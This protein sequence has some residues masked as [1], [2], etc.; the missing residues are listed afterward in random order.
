ME[1]LQFERNKIYEK[2]AYQPEPVDYTG[3]LPW[4]VQQQIA[5]TNGIHYVDR[6]GKLNWYPAYELPVKQSSGGLMLDIGTGWGR[7]LV[8]GARKGFLPIGVDLRLEFCQAS[9]QTLAN[10]KINGYAVVADLKELPFED[11]IFSLIWSFSVIQH[12]H[13]VR[14]ES[15]LDNIARMLKKNGI[16]KIQVPNSKGLRNRLGPAKT[17]QRTADQ[18]NSWVVR[19]YSLNEYKRI[20]QKYFQNLSFRNHSF[21]GIGVLKEDMKYVSY[22]NKLLCSAS[23]LLSGLTKFVKPLI[24][25]SDSIYVEALKNNGGENREKINCFL[26]AHRKDP[27]NNLNVV[28]ILQCPISKQNL[29]LTGDKQAIV[30]MDG[31]ISYPVKDSIPV[32]IRSEATVCEA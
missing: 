22:K 24:H 15:C 31:K 32:M 10:H 1:N 16:T 4:L 19:Y 20:F 25:F 27:S 14:M 3:K 13:R 7:W 6:I 12:T 17:S 30:T 5:A 26:E 18:Y 21:L 8:A 23:L 28:H 29:R 2:L 11:D 9:R